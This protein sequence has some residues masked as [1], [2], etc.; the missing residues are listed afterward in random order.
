MCMPSGRTGLSL[1]RPSAV[2]SRSP[3]SLDQHFRRVSPGAVVT[4]HGGLDGEDLAVEAAF[5]PRPGGVLLRL[6]TELVDVGPG[7]PVFLGDPFGRAELVGHVPGEVVGTGPAARAAR[8]PRADAA[9]GLDPA[10]DADIDGAGSD[11]VGHE[12]VG[13]L[14]RTALAVDGG[15]GHL[16]GQA[17][18]QPRRPGHI[19]GLLPGLGHAAADDLLDAPGSIPAR[20]T[21]ST[22]AAPSKWAAWSPDS[23]PLRFPI[24]VRTASMITGCAMTECPS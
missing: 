15:G 21:S 14:G 10:P 8:W 2:V 23:Q 16:V 7:D 5:G 6:E 22:W 20:L 1:A 13:L 17:L 18:V 12:V 11:Q 4:D 19:G 9:H 3:W 24:G